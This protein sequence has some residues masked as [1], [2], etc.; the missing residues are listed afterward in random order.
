MRPAHGLLLGLLILCAASLWYGLSTDDDRESLSNRASAPAAAESRAGN[1]PTPQVLLSVLNGT[2]IP[3]LA[4]DVGMLVGRAGCLAGRIENAP[5]DRFGRSLLIN[6]RLPDS[7][8]RELAAALG[9]LP[10]IREADLRAGEDAV[11][12]LG[13]DYLKVCRT[14]GLDLD[15]DREAGNP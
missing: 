14:L 1:P 13:E 2:D 5:H 9:G 15:S 11:L 6:R 12:V 4:G 8:A 3:R 10:V 7:R